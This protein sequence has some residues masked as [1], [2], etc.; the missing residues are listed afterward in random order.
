MD[1]QKSILITGCSTGIGWCA[2]GTLHKRGYQVFA[3]A[4]K[5]EDLARLSALGVTS[6]PL[7]MS[8]SASIQQAVTTVLAKTGGTLDALFNNVGYAIPGAVE[9]LS[10]DMMR[11]Q[12]EAN[13]FGL[14]ELTNLIVP[15]MRKQGHGRIVH[16]TSILGVITMPY[17]GNYNASK[18]ALEAYTSTLRQELRDTNIKVCIIAPGPIATEFRSTASKTFESHLQDKASVHQS[19][20][21]KMKAHFSQSSASET[22]LTLPPDAVV[23]KLI[24]ALESN[25]PRARYY[26]GLPAHLFAWLRRLLPD[27]G[28]DWVIAKI[29]SGE[30]K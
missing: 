8:D 22:K 25:H 11:T 27:K 14:M 20:Y 26:V 7:E 4:R 15:V 1:M 9:D 24:D 28:L 6:I 18:F 3:T 29:M 16:N 10:R 19:N 30:T 23:A 21:Q 2:A 13:V 17:R 12:F 5:A